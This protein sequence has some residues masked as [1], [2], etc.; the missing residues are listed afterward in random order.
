MNE[1]PYSF[2][3]N[4]T[5]AFFF[6]FYFHTAF[7]FGLCFLFVCK[8]KEDFLRSIFQRLHALSLCETNCNNFQ[9]ERER[10]MQHKK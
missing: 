6:N 4:I 5:Q 9:T 1:K 2:V 8:I 7:K 3:R 10:E